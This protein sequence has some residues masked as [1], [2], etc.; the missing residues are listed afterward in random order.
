MEVVFGGLA[1][2][3]CLVYLDDVIMVGKMLE[4]ISRSLSEVEDDR[5]SFWGGS[6]CSGVSWAHCVSTQ[7][8]HKGIHIDLEKLQAGEELPMPSECEDIEIILGHASY[9]RKFIAAFAKVATPFTP[10]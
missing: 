3:G 5:N 4:E 7:G 1:K 10:H 9:Y 2:G 6:D 8:I